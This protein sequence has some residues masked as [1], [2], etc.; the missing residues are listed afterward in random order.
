MACA[1]YLAP[2]RLS[3]PPG[4]YLYMLLSAIKTQFT[5][6]LRLTYSSG[7]VTIGDPRVELFQPAPPGFRRRQPQLASTGLSVTR[8]PRRHAVR[9][10]TPATPNPAGPTP[11]SPHVHRQQERPTPP[12]PRP[13]GQQD[14]RSPHLHSHSTV[15]AAPDSRRTPTGTHDI[16]RDSAL[17]RS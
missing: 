12:S 9:A 7:S 1:P 15:H 11:T 17:C 13:H 10:S 4:A 5:Y 2:D 14:R 3:R 8:R 6:T 16:N